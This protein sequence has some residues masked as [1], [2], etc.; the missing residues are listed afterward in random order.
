MRIA[1]LAIAALTLTAA[2]AA[3]QPADPALQ[4][5]A[6]CAALPDPGQ[7][8][9]CYDAA[10]AALNGAIRSGEISLIRKKE[11]QAARREAFGFQLP[12][13]AILDK[14]AKEEGPIDTLT[15]E[16]KD[17]RLDREGNWIITLGSGAVWVQT[18]KKTLAPR[19][20]VGQKVEIRKAVLG[21]F[22]LKVADLPAVRAR[23]VE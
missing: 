19:P 2:E 7:K 16:I 15:D 17:A 20:K 12:S 9:G 3:A 11:A 5:L 1:A 18:D 4:G 22:F 10:Y 23:R 8:A 13:L 14:V 21:S 6:A